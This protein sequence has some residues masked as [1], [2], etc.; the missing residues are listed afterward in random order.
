[1]PTIAPA[2][3]ETFAIELL[4]AGGATPSE[5]EVVGK[6]LVSA[7]L[8]GYESHGVMRIPFYLQ[9]LKDG[10][11]VSQAPLE[12]LNQ[13]GTRV[14]AD[15]HW[16]FG[17]VQANQ[18]LDM[19]YERVRLEGLAIGTLIHSGHI[20]RLG[21]YCEA[22]AARNLISMLMV[23]SHGAAVR[24]APPGGTAPRLS[25]N[26]LAIGVPNGAE[27]LVLDFSTSAT[28]EG[29]VRVKKIA[30]EKVPDG[31]LLDNQG[32][33]TNDPNTLYGNPPGSILP[34][35]GAQAYKGF[36]LGLMIE[37]LTGALSGG[38]CA[39]EVPYP[40]KGN[41]VFVLLMD[42]AA[43]GGAE[44]FRS[45]VAQLTEYIRNCPRIDGCER[46]LLPGDPERITQ[47]AR[48]AKG[49]TLDSENWNQLAKLAHGLQVTTPATT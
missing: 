48:L 20:G 42:P 11:V 22:A 2:A 23:N 39:R 7:N 29:K 37:I 14:V 40:K 27:P 13:S 30:G 5:A 44:H 10:E 43:F 21:E 46:I 49:V 12:V 45:E 35:G 6:S 32:R 33:P 15:A 18:L 4:R 24:V 25:T 31:W 19:L 47:A 34:M 3:L 41:C 9:A 36:G 26:P 28:A 1:M 38:V 8:C 17:Q 16:G